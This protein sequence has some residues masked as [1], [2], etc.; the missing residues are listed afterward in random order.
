M[1]S[2]M[3]KEEYLDLQ[4]EHKFEKTHKKLFNNK[5]ELKFML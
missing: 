5:G 4:D 3:S 1:E 2:A